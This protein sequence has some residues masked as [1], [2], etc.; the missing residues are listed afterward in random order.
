MKFQSLLNDYRYLGRIAEATRA[1]LADLLEDQH[2]TAEQRRQLDA[3]LAHLTDVR[4]GFV[5]SLRTGDVA[6][7]SELEALVR[8]ILFDWRW[9]EE[10]GL[11]LLPET[12]V[13]LPR[14]QLLSF[15]HSYL[16]LALM[17]RLPRQRVTFPNP[18]SY[19][20]IPVPRRP[21]E[22]LARIEELEEVLTQ[23][24]G[25]ERA[26]LS[27]GSFRRTYGFFETSAWLVRD[28][29]RLFGRMM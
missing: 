13:H 29:M 24:Q 23:V 12:E 3:T 22:I 27:V 7:T 10:L 15:A 2:L 4:E 20:D 21:G 9:L 1:L 26:R 28:H 18:K 11:E 14:M 19:A 17:P 16:A 5:L 25:E 8:H 6:D